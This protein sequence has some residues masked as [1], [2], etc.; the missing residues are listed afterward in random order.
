MIKRGFRKQFRLRLMQIPGLLDTHWYMT[1]RRFS[2]ECMDS[3][4]IINATGDE[5]N[6]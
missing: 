6:K 1:A 5:R 3:E 2:L 4:K